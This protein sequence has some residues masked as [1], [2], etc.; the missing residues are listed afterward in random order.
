M[1]AAAPASPPPPMPAPFTAALLRVRTS[2][3]DMTAE[4]MGRLGFSIQLIT[5]GGQPAVGV[6][7]GGGPGEPK[8]NS[9]LAC[10][11]CAD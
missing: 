11:T 5:P 3:A 9:L 1:L 2:G 8:F 4:V 10:P 7:W 6:G